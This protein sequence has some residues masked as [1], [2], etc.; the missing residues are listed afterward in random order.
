MARK[1]STGAKRDSEARA[2]SASVPPGRVDGAGE[3]KFRGFLEAAPDAVV[4]VGR[5]G[6]IM[7]VN[8]QTERIFGHSREELIGKPV[9]VLVPERYRSGHGAHRV[10]YFADPR[11]R[12]MG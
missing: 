6:T 3:H 4:I 5:D 12:S 7:I 11:V 10:G 1:K 2:A 8:S 9:E